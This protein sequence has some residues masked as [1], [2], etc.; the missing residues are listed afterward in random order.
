[1]NVQD[2]K[3]HNPWYIVEIGSKGIVKETGVGIIGFVS[4][5]NI[6]KCS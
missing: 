6:L 4:A 2:I 3:E 5:E 1:M